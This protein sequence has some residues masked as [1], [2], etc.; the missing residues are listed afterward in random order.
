MEKHKLVKDVKLLR[1]GVY[2]LNDIIEVGKID[3]VDK[4]IVCDIFYD[5]K[6][7]DEDSA[8]KVCDEFLKNTIEKLR[9][10]IQKEKHNN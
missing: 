10:S 1:E 7:I 4:D 8:K 6:Q 5:E 9:Q 2:L 3:I